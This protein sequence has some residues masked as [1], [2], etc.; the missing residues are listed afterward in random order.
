VGPV[1]DQAGS[2]THLKAEEAH[3]PTQEK[4][5]HNRVVRQKAGVGLANGL[6]CAMRQPSEVAGLLS[7]YRQLSRIFQDVHRDFVIG[8]GFLLRNTPTHFSFY[9]PGLAC[10]QPL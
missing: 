2:A 6:A 7:P 10:A 3:R 1:R 4:N 8:L 9:R 5:T